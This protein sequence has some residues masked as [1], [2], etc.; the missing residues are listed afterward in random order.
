MII[1]GVIL[2]I[3]G[4]AGIIYAFTNYNSKISYSMESVIMF[5]GIG[6]FIMGLVT[7]CSALGLM[8]NNDK[9]ERI[10]NSN[11]VK[12]EEEYIYTEENGKVEK[13]NAN[14]KISYN[15]NIDHIILN[16]NKKDGMWRFSKI[17]IIYPFEA[18]T[19]EYEIIIKED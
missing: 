17:E 13:I 9:I 1:T 10:L 18:E 14:P 3:S 16:I 2:L 19:Q 12:I 5:V 8:E 7:S 6:A 15:T 11:I 4:G